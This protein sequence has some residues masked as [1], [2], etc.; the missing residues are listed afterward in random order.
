MNISNKPGL[1]IHIPFC[2]SKCG[3]CDFYSIIDTSLIKPFINALVDEIKI[4][5]KDLQSY[6]V[7]DTI[8][9]GGGTPSLLSTKDLELLLCTIKN[10]YKIHNN[11][12]TTIEVNPGTLNAYNLKEIYDLGINRISIGVQS[13]IDSDL[14]AAERIHTSK[15]AIS[16]IESSRNTGFDN[17]NLDL[18]FALPGQTVQDWNYTLKNAVSFNPEHLSIYNLTFEEGTPFYQKKKLGLLVAHNEE[19]EILL[20]NMGHELLAN[21]SYIHYEVSNYAKSADLI[22]KHNYKYW[23]HTP[24]LGFG[25][26]AH[27]FWNN[28]RWSNKQSVSE[29]IKT[30]ALGILPREMHEELNRDDLMLEHI[31]L[32]LRTYRGLNLHNFQRTFEIRFDDIFE[33]EI[34]TLLGDN[35]ARIES[36]NFQLTQKGML[37]CDELI[38]KFSFK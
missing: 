25:P 35:L 27:S 31:F 11:C 37:I 38:S 13:F 34:Q 36:G 15:E 3:Y 12:E 1:Y 17:I 6:A 4:T 23:T 9:L 10:Y 29:Y 2:Q 19:K 26:S 7:F 24:Y 8:Y 33:Q 32:S 20:F 16:T 5:S 30:L 28:T 18:I 22:S 14:I 21:S